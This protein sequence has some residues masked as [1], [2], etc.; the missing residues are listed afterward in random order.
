MSILDDARRLEQRAPWPD[1]QAVC[2]FCDCWVGK[3]ADTC[4][5]LVLPR[6]VA[7]LEAADLVLWGVDRDS[8]TMHVALADLRKAMQGEDAG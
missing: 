8:A 7:A 4:P 3:H 6:I 1:D 2:P 5:W